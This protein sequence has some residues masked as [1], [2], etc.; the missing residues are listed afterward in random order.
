MY[1]CSV[2]EGRFWRENDNMYVVLRKEDFGGKI[3]CKED[4]AGK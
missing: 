1:V 2:K 3:I 4:L